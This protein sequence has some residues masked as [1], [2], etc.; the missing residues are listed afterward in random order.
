MDEERGLLFAGIGTP[1]NDYYGG[2]RKGDNLYAEA[3]VAIDARTGELAW[4]YQTVHHGLWDFDLPGAP[5]LMTIAPRG[6]AVDAVAVAGKTGFVYTFD[7]ATGEPVW[8]IEERPV[9]PSE[10]PGEVA[11]ATQPF[12]TLPPPFARQGFTPDDLIDLTPELRRQAEE[13]TAG[14]RFGSLFEPPSMEGT[15]TMPGILGGGNWGGAAF[16]PGTGVLFVKSSED[17][18]LLT[19]G[20]G[21]PETMVGD[22]GI[23]RGAP[24]SLRIGNVPITNPPWGTLTAIDMNA[25]EILWQEAVGDGPR[26]AATPRSQVWRCPP[27][28]AWWVRRAP[29][30]PVAAWS[31]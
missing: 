3:L 24:R 15:I 8:P 29:S 28:W 5:V 21:N 20:P 4:H 7:R 30:S 1:S 18:S 13:L 6:E 25:A 31:S 10:V 12:P 16:D 14:Y 19:I 17:P 2:H 26:C 23:D 22:Y 11:A 27:G 9:P